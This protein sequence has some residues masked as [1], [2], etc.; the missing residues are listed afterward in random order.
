MDRNF[1][2]MGGHFRPLPAVV[3]FNLLGS[4]I[5][6]RPQGAAQQARSGE[7]RTP[8][9]CVVSALGAA[10]GEDKV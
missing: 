5:P 6:T 7:S 3:W 2:S 10:V 1:H 4:R 9:V 8:G